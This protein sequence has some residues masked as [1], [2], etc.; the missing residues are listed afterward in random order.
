[1]GSKDGTVVRA[2]TSHQCGPGTIPAQCHIWVEFV[3]GSYLAPGFFSGFSFSPS[4]K[5]N[6]F[7]FQFDQDRGPATADVASSLNFVI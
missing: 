7:K 5:T 6:V 1:M 3:V 4:K 2:L